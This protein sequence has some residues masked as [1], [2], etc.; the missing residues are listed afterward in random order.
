MKKRSNGSLARPTALVVVLAGLAAAAAVVGAA[1]SE[2]HG[3]SP[4][5]RHDNGRHYGWADWNKWPGHDYGHGHGHGGGNHGPKPLPRTDVVQTEYGAVKGFIKDDVRTFLGMPLA[6]PPV[7][8]LRWRP[9]V[10]PAKWRGVRDAVEYGSM[11]AQN[12]RLLDF[13]APSTSEDCLYIN[14]FAPAKSPR[15]RPVMVWIHGGGHTVGAGDG[16]D[17]SALVQGNDVLVVTFNYRLNA[18][19]FLVHPALDGSGKTTNY[20]FLDQTFAL[21]WV[22][23]NIA[24]FGGDPD[25]VTIFGESA[26]GIAVLYQLISPKSK[27]LFHRAIIESGSVFWRKLPTLATAETAGMNFAASLGCTDQ[28]AA[29]LRNLSVQQ[30]LSIGDQFNTAVNDGYTLNMNYRE[31]F[32]TGRFNRVPILNGVNRDEYRWFTALSEV[33]SGH[34]VTADEYSERLEAVFGVEA[35]PSVERLYPL[36]KYGSPSEALSAAVGDGNFVICGS[37]NLN[38]AASKYVPV[39]GYEF[40]DR[41]SPQVF[42]PVSFPYGAAHTSEIQ[43][44]FRNYRGARVE[45]L[46]PLSRAQQELSKQMVAYWGTFA[47]N[48][49]PNV[50]SQPRW[51][52][53]AKRDDRVMELRT[54]AP[55]VISDFAKVHHCEFWDDY[56]LDLSGP[57]N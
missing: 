53:Y 5:D 3:N 45:P 50:R 42:P 43:Y 34:V 18:F 35:A 22:Q 14:V 23:R 54:G 27:G 9:P 39:Y 19:G 13:G 7:G 32:E 24:A 10:K 40:T 52:R 6:A 4:N 25:N 20:G 11:C 55:R 51:P 44:I 41:N 26:G 21:K 37:R 12:K 28:S 57:I 8:D 47:E 31:A 17:G 48:G 30:I 1:Q 36:H 16:H 29:C 2:A 49:D 38:Q 33:N 46:P 15:K 56:N